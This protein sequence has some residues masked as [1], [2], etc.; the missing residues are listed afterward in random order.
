MIWLQPNALEQAKQDEQKIWQEVNKNP[1]PNSTL[2]KRLEHQSQQGIRI[3]HYHTD[4]LG[5]PQELTNDRGDVVWLNYSLAWG[6]S[7]DKL[8]NVHNLDGL[9]ISADLLQPIRFQGQFFD[10]ET[11]LHYN[12]FR[13]YDSDVGMFV[14]RDPIGLEGG[15]N[16]FQYAP[17]PVMWIDPLGLIKV[18]RALTLTQGYQAKFNLPILPTNLSA[19]YSM[20]QHVEIGS[21]IN[22]QY[23]SATKKKWTAI[24]KYGK[25]NPAKGKNCTSY[26]IEIDTD[27]LSKSQV[28]DIS[29]GI[30]PETGKAFLRKAYGYSKGDKEVLIVGAI[31]KYAYR[32][33]AEPKC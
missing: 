9:D 10:G 11:N 8:N 21:K 15:F 3:Y 6:G 7:F 1:Y 16:I 2:K 30:N 28:F 31:P 13:Y 5:T 27:H 25:A 4:H 14:S 29:N 19:K 18:Y 33:I 22:T 32:V 12:R 24:N 17:S 20:Q 26:I 23:I